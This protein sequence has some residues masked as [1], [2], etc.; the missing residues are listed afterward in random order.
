M[1][2]QPSPGLLL[3]QLNTGELNA[4]GQF[5]LSLYVWSGQLNIFHICSGQLNIFLYLFWT[6]EYILYL[7]RTIEYILY[8]FRT[9]EHVFDTWSGQLNANEVEGWELEE[10]RGRWQQT[11][12]KSS[13]LQQTTDLQK[14]F[15][16]ESGFAT[17]KFQ[18]CFLGNSFLETIF[19]C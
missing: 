7:F 12:L 16:F 2:I 1:L 11:V 17:K 19:D 8:L 4:S 5:N 3:H 10:I 15:G 14:L 18:S 9:I 13:S 6:I